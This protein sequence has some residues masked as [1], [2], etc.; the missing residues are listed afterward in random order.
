[1]GKIEVTGLDYVE[2]MLKRFDADVEAIIKIGVYE[3]A[4]VIANA[5]REGI[6][7]LP[8]DSWH[9][10]ASHPIMR[11]PS[12]E[13]KEGLQEGFGISKMQNTGGSI[14]VRIG[15]NGYNK[16]KTLSYSEGQP[17]VLIARSVESGT[18]YMQKTPFVRKALNKAKKQAIDAVQRKV[19]AAAR[20]IAERT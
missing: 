17:N 9:L 4:G 1:M 16:V 10:G 18:S 19:S 5:V 2:K 15:F 12:P 14:N 7:A 20:A 11:G 13:Q 6:D 3:G 8:T